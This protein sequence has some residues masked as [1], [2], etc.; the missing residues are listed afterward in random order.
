MKKSNFIVP[1]VLTASVITGS[2][3]LTPFVAKP[4]YTEAKGGAHNPLKKV[5]FT[6]LAL[7]GVTTLSTVGFGFTL[8][9]L[10][11]EQHKNNHNTNDSSK[12]PEKKPQNGFYF[13]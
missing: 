5:P 6:S 11:N 13:K 4:M 8:N 1:K 9:H 12:T 10:I 7:L 2:L 3:L